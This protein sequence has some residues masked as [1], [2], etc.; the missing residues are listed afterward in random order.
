MAYEHGITV[1]EESTAL[2]PM[3]T[4]S[5]P[6]VVVGTAY[7]GPVNAPTLIQNM[8][9]FVSVFGYADDFEQFTLEEAAY[10]FFQLYNVRP[11]ICVNVLDLSRHKKQTTKSLSG[12]ANPLTITGPIILSSIVITSGADETLKTLTL[13]TDYSLEQD[14][15]EVTITILR[16]TNITNDTIAV[17]YSEADGT[18]VVA[19]DVIGGVNNLGKETGLSVL[20]NIYPKLGMVP[21]AIIA[22]KFSSIPEVA[23]AMAARARLINETFKAVALADI[24][25]S[26]S[27]LTLENPTADRL[28]EG[29]GIARGNILTDEPATDANYADV[30]AY[31]GSHSLADE[32]LAVCWPRVALNDKAYWLSTHAA[33]LMNVVDAG[34]GQ[35]PY[36]SPSNKTLRIDRTLVKSGAEVFLSKP[37]ANTLNGWGVITALNF[38]GSWRLWG[39]RMSCYPADDDPKDA[40]LP[41]RR[42]VN[43]LTS[44]LAINYFSR[45]DAPIN[46]RLVESVVDEVNLYLSGLTAQGVLLGGR[47]AFLEDDNPNTDLADG[48]LKFR[49]YYASPT[50]ARNISFTLAYDVA[51]FSALFS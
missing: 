22:P 10:T 44:T 23:L 51:Y 34:N 15:L 13:D 20:E 38:A 12:T 42:M 19:A 24:D 4:V 50:P 40:W 29:K 39:S 7:K 1:L 3:T 9:D 18:A 27:L 5:S 31:K 46:K 35:I 17:A 49:V 33:A 16:Q 25:M 26:R 43:F 30:Y 14:G 47:I 8:S 32:F 45:I 2:T 11:I 41:V 37:K 28:V 48:K 6:V 21:G 36:E